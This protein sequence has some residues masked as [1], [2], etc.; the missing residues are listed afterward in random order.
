MVLDCMEREKGYYLGDGCYTQWTHS[1]LTDDFTLME[2]LFD[3]F[4]ES[5]FIN[6]GLMTCGCCSLM[7]EIAE[8]PFI[9]IMLAWI[10]LAHSHR[11]DFIR[12]RY[13]KLADILD[14]YRE[15]YADSDGLLHN[16]DK[17]C[18]V[19]WPAAFR[20]NYDVDI[21][22]GKVCTVKHN[23]INAYYIGAVDHKLVTACRKR[24][25]PLVA[26]TIR[27]EKQLEKAR[28]LC[29]GIIFEGIEVEMW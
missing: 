2:K 18:V 13:A 17:W 20:D 19:E 3:D 29:D 6:R 5:S 8:Y 16:L 28:S 11:K 24:N 14:F 26:W 23:V 1:I 9:F 10:Y 27:N 22:E 15:N 4:L 12:E 7:Q 21:A 25:V